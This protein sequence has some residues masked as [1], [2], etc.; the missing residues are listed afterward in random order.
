L[1]SIL[2]KCLSLGRIFEI[3]VFQET[4]L[5]K[6]ALAIGMLKVVDITT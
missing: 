1:K 3:N 5:W 6:Q 4:H 2:K